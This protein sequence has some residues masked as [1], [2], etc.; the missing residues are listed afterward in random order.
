MT[1]GHL[2]LI[3]YFVYEIHITMTHILNAS[4]NSCSK[5]ANKVMA[6]GAIAHPIRGTIMNFG[7]RNSA[8]NL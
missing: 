4:Q 1:D 5:S 3:Q 6:A 8:A 7:V 2:A